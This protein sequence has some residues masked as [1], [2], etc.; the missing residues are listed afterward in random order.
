MLTSTVKSIFSIVTLIFLLCLQACGGGGSSKSAEDPYQEYTFQLQGQLANKC[1]LTNNFINYDFYLQDE[2]W[3]TIKRYQPNSRGVV[4]FV[5]TKEVINYTLVAKTR[6]GD[7]PEG[8]DIVSYQGVKTATPALYLA[9][10]D[11]KV[12]NSACQCVKQDLQLRHRPFTSR[13]QVL[14]SASFATWQAIDERT[15]EFT[16]VEVCR[17]K[18]AT[19][20]NH[21]FAVLG[22]NSN[23][24][25]IGS[26]EFIDDFAETNDDVWQATAVDVAEYELTLDKNHQLVSTSQLISGKHHFSFDLPSSQREVYLFKSHPYISEAVFVS[27]S[28]HQFVDVT[29]LLGTFKLQRQRRITSEIAEQSLD[30]QVSKELP[31]IDQQYLSEL[32]I[33]GSYDFSKVKNYPMLIAEFDYLTLINNIS[34]PVKWHYYGPAKGLLPIVKPPE[35]YQDII[36]DKNNIYKTKI[37]LL[38]SNATN[39]YQEYIAYAQSA[40]PRDFSD[41]IER[42]VLEVD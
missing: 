17:D 15:T 35:D 30:V 32:N 20:P 39:K 11:S 16:D 36:G 9:D 5:I 26:A 33:D 13:D 31:E 6:S 29:S 3:Q 41:D 28:S 19:W 4:S 37:T 8:Y 1:G 21:S 42:L 7:K 34:I 10:Y 14:S 2:N 40:N 38:K 27:E 23:D 24:E 25:V 22:K 18:S 12:N